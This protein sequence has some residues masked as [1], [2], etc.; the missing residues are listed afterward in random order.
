M[1]KV[2]KVALPVFEQGFTYFPNDTL[3]S[4]SQESLPSFLGFVLVSLQSGHNLTFDSDA[5]LLAQ[6][7]F[8][9]IGGK[10]LPKFGYVDLN[11]RA[12]C[13]EIVYRLLRDSA[14]DEVHCLVRLVM[15]F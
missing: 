3:G 10:I 13:T 5:D 14:S 6:S 7:H 4:I 2:I 11:R 9:Q 12:S 8:G 15:L 1:S